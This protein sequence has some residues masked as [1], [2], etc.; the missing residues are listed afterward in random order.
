MLF[1]GEKL[2]DWQPKN[3][4]RRYKDTRNVDTLSMLIINKWI[5]PPT[6]GGGPIGPRLLQRQIIIKTHKC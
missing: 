2:Q 5:N 1:S 6:Y 3:F 4:Y